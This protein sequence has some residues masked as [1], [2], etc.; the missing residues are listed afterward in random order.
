[1]HRPDRHILLLGIISGVWATSAC[2]P[3]TSDSGPDAHAEHADL[4]TVNAKTPPGDPT[5]LLSDETVLDVTD[6][7]GMRHLVMR[8]VRAPGTR[9]PIHVHPFGGTTCVLEGQ[10]TLY[11]EGSPE[12]TAKAGDCYWM[13]PGLP[14]SGGNTGSTN[15]VLH[16]IFTVPAGQ[17]VWQVVERGQAS[18]QGNFSTGN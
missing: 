10:M 14:M 1:M 7:D 3:V 13:P 12:V 2:A 5:T 11:L 8:G 4:M 17:A 9:A 6:A 16:D 15:A 18:M